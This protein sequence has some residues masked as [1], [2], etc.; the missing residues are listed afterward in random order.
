MQIYIVNKIARQYE[1]E[2]VFVQA[3]AAFIDP[4]NVDNFLKTYQYQPAETINGIECV[5]EM[6]TVQ[7]ELKDAEQF[8]GKA[9]GG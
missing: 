7:T 9:I 8:V 1:G 6:G 3:V 5:V 2:Y 4:A